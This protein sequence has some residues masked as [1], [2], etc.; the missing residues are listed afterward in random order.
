MVTKEFLPFLKTP[1]NPY[2]YGSKNSH[3]R[4]ALNDGPVWPCTG[5]LNT[6]TAANHRESIS[7]CRRDDLGVATVNVTRKRRITPVRSIPAPRGS[8]C[9]ERK[10]QPKKGAPSASS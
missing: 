1:K 5:A 7:A 10:S 9:G 8:A 6:C 4:A 2:Y 3:V